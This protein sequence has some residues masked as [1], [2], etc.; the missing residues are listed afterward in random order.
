MAP[1]PRRGLHTV[2]VG[3]GTFFV[4]AA[5]GKLP[6]ALPTLKGSNIPPLAG[7]P[8]GRTRRRGT[9]DPSRVEART[10]SST[11]GG[12]H[13]ERALAHGYSILAPP[14]RVDPWLHPL[15]VQQKMWDT[16]SWGRRG[17]ARRGVRG[18]VP[19]EKSCARAV[20][21]SQKAKRK[22]Q[23]VKV[24]PP[25]FGNV[26]VAARVFDPL[27]RPAPADES[28]GCSPPSPPRGRGICLSLVTAGKRLARPPA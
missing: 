19:R 11:V 3:K 1:Q 17:T 25:S 6:T 4:P 2:A 5:H 8:V 28:A 15:R 10:G 22:S 20:K 27:T 23:K 26:S 24:K 7:S 9:F 16:F 21:A 13:K 14:G 12:G 18:F